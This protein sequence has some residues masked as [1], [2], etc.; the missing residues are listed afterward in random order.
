MNSAAMLYSMTNKKNG[1]VEEKTVFLL[2]FQSK[3][4]SHFPKNNSY[5]GSK[6]IIA[7]FKGR[8][9]KSNLS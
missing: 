8:L 1:G 9:L 5:S 4:I 2:S 7:S 6:F 3:N